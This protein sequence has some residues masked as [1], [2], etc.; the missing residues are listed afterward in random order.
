MVNDGLPV[1]AIDGKT[2]RRS[3]DGRKGRNP[4]HLVSVW[5]ARP[6]LV[7]RQQATEQ[8]S[9]KVTAFRLLI[10]HLDP[11]GARMIMDA[12]GIQAALVPESWT[13]GKHDHAEWQRTSA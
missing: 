8:K 11:Q 9:N 1:I 10:R 2:S 13:E 4:L 7:P 6:R 3:H 5:A 12:M